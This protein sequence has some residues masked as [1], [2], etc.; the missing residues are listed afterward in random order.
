M[1]GLAV[2]A[3]VEPTADGLARGCRD[4]GGAAQVHPGGLAAQSFR[5]VPG[6]D[7]QQCRGVSADPVEGQ[8]PGGAGAARGPMAF[9]TANGSSG[10]TV[11]YAAMR[12]LLS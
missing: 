6:R 10:G 3:R 8:E 1:V 2:A 11:A 9:E 5:V 4:G 7:E 12:V